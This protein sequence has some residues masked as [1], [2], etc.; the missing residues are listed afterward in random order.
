M[1]TFVL[2]LCYFA[3]VLTILEYFSLVWGSAA[4][5]HLQL[6]ERL[7]YS[8]AR[9]F[10]DQ[11]FLSLC[12]LRRVVELIML[13]KVNS[14]SNHCLFSELPSAVQ[15]ANILSGRT[16]SA[17]GWHYEGRTFDPYSLQQVLRFVASIAPCNTWSSGGTALCRVGAA[18]SPLDLSSL[19]L[20]SVAC[21]G[22]LQL[23]FP[24]W[25]T[26]VDY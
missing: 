6:L 10:L 14:N 15:R 25:A 1:D 17:F 7:V 11:S 16:D 3:F 20:L 18:T 2:L 5:C 22:R 9:L 8:V 24:H 26:S 4:K 19:T 21:C 12:Y 13:Y 23:G